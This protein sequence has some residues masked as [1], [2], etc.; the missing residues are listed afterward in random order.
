MSLLG[1]FRVQNGVMRSFLV[2][3]TAIALG[4]LAL[5]CSTPD[6]KSQDEGTAPSQMT[7][8]FSEE[9]TK[10]GLTLPHA[11]FELFNN[12]SMNGGAAAQDVDND[13]DIDLYLTRYNLPN[14]L[15][16]NDGQGIFEDRAASWGVDTDL[17]SGTPLFADF[18]GDKDLDLAVTPTNYG[19]FVLFTNNGNNTMTQSTAQSGIELDYRLLG[20]ETG[21][22]AYAAEAFDYDNDGDLDLAI[23]EWG[24]VKGV[25]DKQDQHRSYLY[26]NDGQAHFTDVTAAV[27]LES[28]ASSAVFALRF[29][30]IDEDGWADLLVTGDFGTSRVFRSI[31]GERFEEATDRTL[32]TAPFESEPSRVYN[33][34]ASS[35]VDLEG[36]GEWTWI[37]SG[38]GSTLPAMGRKCF[39]DPGAS[40]DSDFADRIKCTGNRAT[41]LGSLDAPWIDRT[42]E[43]GI[44]NGGWAW[45]IAA[46]DFDLDGDLDVAQTNGYHAKVSADA[47]DYEVGTYPIYEHS[48]EDENR[49]WLSVGPRTRMT[50]VAD[51]VGFNQPTSGRALVPVDIDLDGDTD[52]LQVNNADTPQLFVNQS[53]PAP[54]LHLDFTYSGF[55]NA[56]IGCIITV[57]S[58][59]R[60][61]RRFIAG[62]GS[63]ASQDPFVASFGF[64]AGTTTVDSITISSPNGT[65]TTLNDQKVNQV[66]RP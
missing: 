18:D 23:G 4:V 62:S 5:G 65:Q 58:G 26:E 34:M 38:I 19:D 43:L 20:G 3:G 12:P 6:T 52:V 56:Y 30:D 49:V 46:A 7:L 14:Q 51:L 24:L 55:P 60:T 22:F 59:E 33:G 2:A 13:G 10:R 25:H 35:I 39:E 27:G 1:R 29:F 42:G 40:L 57:V 41:S 37:Q 53:P 15:L 54:W 17:A 48:N 32:S 16:I 28:L 11:P 44:R 61:Q 50:E 31:N 36:Q 64:Q 66:L 63:Y 21:P 9:G 47:D 45:G 8:R